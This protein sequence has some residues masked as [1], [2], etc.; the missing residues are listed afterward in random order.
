MQALCGRNASS[1]DIYVMELALQKLLESTVDSEPMLHAL[2]SSAYQSFLRAYAA[3]SKAEKR[4]SVAFGTTCTIPMLGTRA[5]ECGQGG[6]L[7]A[8]SAN[9]AH[10]T[11]CIF[12]SGASRLLIAAFVASCKRFT[13]L[14]QPCSIDVIWH[15]MEDLRR[16]S[17]HSSHET[18]RIPTVIGMPCPYRIFPLGAA[19]PAR[20]HVALGPFG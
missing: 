1:R 10:P 15:D 19:G 11:R 8:R 5:N 16:S 12:D 14:L 4:V 6:A 17:H 18:P 13:P 2:S 20:L 7:D 3:H 9:K